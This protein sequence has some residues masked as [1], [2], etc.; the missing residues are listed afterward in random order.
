MWNLVILAVLLAV[1]IGVRDAWMCKKQRNSLKSTIKSWGLNSDAMKYNAVYPSLGIKIASDYAIKAPVSIHNWQLDYSVID[2]VKINANG[3]W[4]AKWCIEIDLQKAGLLDAGK[5]E[6][7]KYLTD[8][9]IISHN[10][11]LY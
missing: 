2:T 9:K 3:F 10:P 6:L 8:N 7:H 4:A 1:F 11:N 5:Y